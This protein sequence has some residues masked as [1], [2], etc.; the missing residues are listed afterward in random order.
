MKS[1]MECSVWPAA[2]SGSLEV[3][4]RQSS[5]AYG[6]Y[7]S[8]AAFLFQFFGTDRESKSVLLSFEKD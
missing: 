5:A 7:L 1:L 6:T 2:I 4:L 3:R 8:A